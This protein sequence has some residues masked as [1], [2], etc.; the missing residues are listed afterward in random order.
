MGVVTPTLPLNDSIFSSSPL[1]IKAVKQD[2]TEDVTDD[3]LAVFIALPEYNLI[4]D[5]FYKLA[6]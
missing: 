4:M 2:T 1:S 5:T 3:S 6:A